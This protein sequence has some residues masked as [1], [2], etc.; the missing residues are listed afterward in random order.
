MTEAIAVREEVNVFAIFDKLDD[1]IIL[2]ELENRVVDT[3]V[4]HF[5]QQGK[6]IWG[7]SKKGV[8]QALEEIEKQGVVFE[9][10]RDI[11]IL[12]D[13]FEPDEYIQIIAQV[14]KFRYAPNGQKF[15]MGV[16]TG[17]KRQ[18]KNE[19]LKD[20]SI[21][22]DRFFFEKG[23]AKAFRN[24][25]S[26]SIPAEVEAKIIALAKSKGKVKTVEEEPEGNGQIVEHKASDK[27]INYIK[28]MVEKKLKGEWDELC[29]QFDAKD[30]DSLL[31]S[32]GVS[33]AKKVIDFLLALKA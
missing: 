23:I 25:K 26:R 33:K 11:Q 1:E 28:G 24:A 22:A 14:R 3:W 13:P 12:P 27:Q 8:D 32:L 19:I 16:L 17:T 30:K 5:N 20:G 9:E 7:L 31:D 18:W 21:R 2:A 15:D 6:E 10:L 4:Y 29:I